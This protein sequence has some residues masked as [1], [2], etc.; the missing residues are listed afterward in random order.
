[1]ADDSQTLHSI[2]NKLNEIENKLIK[3]ETKIESW[4]EEIIRHFG[5]IADETRHDAIGANHD[6][7]E[8]VK[9]R[10]Q[11]HNIRIKKLEDHVGIIT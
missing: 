7:I 9:D 6:T 1:M 10:Q 5:V 3:L 4:K 11:I 8:M 2:K